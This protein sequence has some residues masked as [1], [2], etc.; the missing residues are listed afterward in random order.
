MSPTTPSSADMVDQSP[1]HESNQKGTTEFIT[2]DPPITATIQATPLAY[3]DQ[4][5]NQPMTQLR[6]TAAI[7]DAHLG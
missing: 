5:D 1:F 6:K 2:Q 7:E 4:D 3:E